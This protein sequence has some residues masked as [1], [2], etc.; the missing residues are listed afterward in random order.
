MLLLFSLQTPGG[1]L[2]LRLLSGFLL[3]G[4]R[5]AHLQ[6]RLHR[7]QRLQLQHRA[8]HALRQAGWPS[9]L[10]ALTHNAPGQGPVLRLNSDFIHWHFFLN[11][12]C[13]LIPFT[14]KDTAFQWSWYH[15]CMILFFQDTYVSVYSLLSHHVWQDY[16]DALFFTALNWN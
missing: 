3:P 7:D 1:D 14:L 12:S 4:P 15:F 16:S 6:V 11:S 2:L 13:I 5:T 10:R 9:Q 8:G